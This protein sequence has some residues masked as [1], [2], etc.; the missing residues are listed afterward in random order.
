M[1]VLGWFNNF[2]K[3]R[4]LLS[5][6][7]LREI[8]LKYKRSVLGILWSVLSP[9]LMMLILDVVFSQLFR[10]Q[11]PNFLVYY[12]TGSLIF[13][14]MQEATNGALFSVF[15]NAGLINKVYLPKYVFPI[16]K[17]VSAF[18]NFG[19][20]LIALIIVTLI[21]GVMPSFALVTAPILFVTLF[22]FVLGLS[23][24]LSAYAVFFRDLIHFHGIF[25]LMWMYLTPIF[26]PE[27][28]VPAKIHW[29]VLGNPIYTYVK[30]FRTIIIDMRFPDISQ[31][32][33][34]F[35]WGIASLA[36]GLYI[37]KRSQNRFALYF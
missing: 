32:V 29:L 11:I 9:L 34:C 23:L 26:Y 19:F 12:L 28:I 22:S 17:T 27:N 31:I 37:F 21:T 1:K 6:L 18:V 30:F 5:E 35:L 25:M 4:F 2:L 20:S 14:F 36:L 33:V 10:F 16:A 3:Y 7:V 8:K 13:G 24:I 15:G